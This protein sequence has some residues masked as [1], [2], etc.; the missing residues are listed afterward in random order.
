[1]KGMRLQTSIVEDQAIPLPGVG[2]D[3][4]GVRKQLSVDGVQVTI[5]LRFKNERKA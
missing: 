2:L 5:M 1:V 3:Q 4:A